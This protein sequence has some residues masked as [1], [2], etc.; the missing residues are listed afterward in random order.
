MIT[1]AKNAPGEWL[2]WRLVRGAFFK[3]FSAVHARL[4]PA[5]TDADRARATIYY[6]NHSN[7]WD[8]YACMVLARFALRQPA[9]LMMDERNLRRY[10][11]FTWAGCFSVDRDDGRAAR[12]TLDYAAGVLAGQP[13]SAL[14]IF[15]QG[16]LVPNDR[17]P[18]QFYSGL[19][20]LAARVPGARLVPVAARY[21]FL[22]EQRPEAFLSVGA[23]LDL[24]PGAPVHPRALTAGL[25]ARLTADLD[26]LRADLAAERL[27]DFT[28][29][30]RGRQGI[31][32][33]FDR[34]L[35]RR[36]RASRRLEPDEF[37]TEGGT[38][39]GLTRIGRID[40]DFF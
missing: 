26:T 12:A 8:G 35:L 3:Q 2:V 38:G 10:R 1:A 7:W 37:G 22:Q 15:P 28:P 34:L 23:P 39:H 19:A 6:L 5:R 20:R 27:D 36:R 18:L 11:F 21:E 14:F 30:L 24:E 9:Y 17:R 32:R 13:G 4:R 25:A 31:D 29:L 40:T 16:T 33:T